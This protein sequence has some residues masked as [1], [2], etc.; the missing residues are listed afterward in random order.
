MEGERG[1][2]RANVFQVLLGGILATQSIAAV[3]SQKPAV[4]ATPSRGSSAQ[5]TKGQPV[6]SFKEGRLTVI[7][8]GA[9]LDRILDTISRQAGVAI[10]GADQ[11]G[12]ELVSVQL[13]DIPLEDGL[14]RLLKDRDT[15]FFYGVEKDTPASLSAVWVYPKG[16][17][18]GLAPVPAKD[19]ASTKE[20]EGMLS[21]PDPKLRMRAYQGLVQRKRELALDIVLKALKDGDEWVR[22]NTLY[23][24]VRSGVELPAEKL[25]ELALNDASP[26]VRFLGLEALS[27]KNSPN[28][29]SIAEQAANDPDA[30][31]QVMAQQIVGRLEAADRPAGPKQRAQ[32]TQPTTEPQ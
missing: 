4:A 10:L 16:Q 24:A 19:W 25:E 31:I 32:Q 14:R 29:R 17:G 26:N 28:L 8:Q 30:N 23:Y 2:V 12:A 18:R 15:F 5:A 11:G 22:A 6:V 21:D 13:Q 7:A 20:L 27:N 1:W 3:A 9:A